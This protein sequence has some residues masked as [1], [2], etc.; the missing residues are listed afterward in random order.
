MKPC[1]FCNNERGQKMEISNL[2]AKVHEL[3]TVYGFIVVVAIVIF[4]TE[5]WVAKA[6]ANL[7]KKTMTKSNTDM[8]LVKV[9][10]NLSYIA[11]LAFVII[12][13]INQIGIQVTSFIAILGAAGLAIVMALP[14]SIENFVESVV[15]IL[16]NHLWWAILLKWR[17]LPVPLKKI[18]FLR[19]NV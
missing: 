8:T 7:I 12:V 5:R 1:L 19:L 11:L 17:V 2:F 16:F 3:L 6:I 15:I 13:A 10:G 4:V 14:G 18:R 9:V